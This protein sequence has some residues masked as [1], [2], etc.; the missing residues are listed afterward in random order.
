MFKLLK[1]SP[2]SARIGMFIVLVNLIACIF[3]P[4]LTPYGEREIIGDVWDPISKSSW[5]GTDQLGRDLL[6]RLIYGARNTVSMAFA[7]TVLSFI[8][9]TIGGFTAAT[10]GKWVDQLLSRMVDILMAFPTLIFALIVLTVLGTSVPILIV[11]IALLNSTRVYRLSRAL[12]MDIEVMEY[13]E[14]A[15]VRGEGLWW[16]MRHEILPNTLPPLIA[17]FGLRYCFAFLFISGLS[18]LGLGIQPPTAD[19]GGM[20]RENA[21]AITFGIYTPLFPAAAIAILTIGVN[22]IVDWFLTIS[23][24]VRGAK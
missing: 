16:V 9:G 8:V 13:V 6:T 15:R 10:V 2:L 21:V 18:F 11:V 12:A 23:S 22:L 7:I 19:W 17:E 20:V 5:L 24:T 3:T 4:Y 14:A 1:K